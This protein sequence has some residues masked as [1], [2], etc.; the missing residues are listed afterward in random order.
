MH[1]FTGTPSELRRAIDLGCFFSVNHAMLDGDR[2]KSVVAAI[3]LKRMLTETDGPFTK[4][5]GRPSMPGDVASTVTML[6]ELFGLEP[7]DM[8][9]Q[10]TTNLRSLIST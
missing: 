5:S 10:I 9:R 1:W 2:R 8:A 4:I 6:A 3:P 7:L